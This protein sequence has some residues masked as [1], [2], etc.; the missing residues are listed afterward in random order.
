MITVPRV[1]VFSILLL[2]GAGCSGGMWPALPS[3]STRGNDA[4]VSEISLDLSGRGLTRVPEDI[5]SHINLEVLNL[6]NNALTGALPAEIRSLQSLRSLD[7]S[8][9]DMTGI[10][11]E[12]GQL[13]ALQYLDLSDNAFTGLPNELGNLT[14]LIWLDLRG[15]AIAMQDLEGIRE[16]LLNTEILVDSATR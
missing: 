7:A 9:N 14:S 5:F 12:I 16:K 15:N 1:I 2:I 4:Q 11:A 3:T 10:P 8:T 6:S 13:S